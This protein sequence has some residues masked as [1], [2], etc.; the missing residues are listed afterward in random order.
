MPHRSRPELAAKVW[1]SAQ[2]YCHAT[3]VV[4]VIGPASAQATD[5][6]SSKA[7]LQPGRPERKLQRQFGFFAAT[8]LATRVSWSSAQTQLGHRSCKRSCGEETKLALEL[9]LW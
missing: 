8:P 5:R 2:D 1:P 4:L 7:P 3:G 9:S 6:T